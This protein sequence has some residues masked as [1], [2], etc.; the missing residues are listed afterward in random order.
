MD[1]YLVDR[2]NGIMHQPGT[3]QANNQLLF[4]T[5][6]HYGYTFSPPW[7]FIVHT[8]HSLYRQPINSQVVLDLL[9]MSLGNFVRED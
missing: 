1:L 5:Y 6:H 2:L 8:L 9:N 7:M 4:F 3:D